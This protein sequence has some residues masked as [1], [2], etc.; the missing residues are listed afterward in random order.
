MLHGGDIYSHKVLMEKDRDGLLLDYSINTNPLGMPDPVKAALRDHV[1]EYGRYPDPSCRALRAALSQ[2]EGVNEEQICCGNGAA[3]LIF[4]ICLAQKPRR[5]LICAPAFSEYERAVI[6]AGG[7][8]ALHRLN[9]T[10]GFALTRRYL[11]DL[12]PGLDMA[13]LC[14]PNNPTGRLIDPELLAEILRRCRELRILLVVDECFLPFTGAASLASNLGPSLVVVKAFTKTF[15]L[16]GLRMGYA[17]GPDSIFTEALAGTGQRW[18]VSTPAQAASCAAL[19]CL[20]WLEQSRRIIETERPCLAEELRK[21]GFAV[22]DSDAN[23]L[24][25]RSELP[26]LHGLME[27]GILIRDCSSFRGLDGR[28]YRCCVKQREQNETFIG[29]IKEVL[30]D[31]GH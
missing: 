30:H 22:F 2:Y 9:E 6:M 16:A 19:Q 4:R 10:E 11:E 31:Q 12:V 24:L 1:E 28:Y 14:N 20:P 23:F 18:S 3:D 17:L 7:E 26:L 13:F 29:M 25:F 21:L 15:S 8:V 27:R 5:A